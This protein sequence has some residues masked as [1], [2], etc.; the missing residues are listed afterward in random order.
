MTAW[1]GLCFHLVCV[2]VPSLAGPKDTAIATTETV[3][4]IQFW[5]VFTLLSVGRSA[6]QFSLLFTVT[7]FVCSHWTKQ[8]RRKDAPVCQFRQYAG[9][10][11]KSGTTAHMT[12]QH[13]MQLEE[14]RGGCGALV[15]DPCTQS[16]VWNEA[17]DFANAGVLEDSPIYQPVAG[18]GLFPAWSSTELKSDLLGESA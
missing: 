6:D 3:L 8:L 17:T 9:S 1:L 11:T 15:Q 14:N 7:A 5:Q 2:R 4:T 18:T 10:G 13:H 12:V 16:A